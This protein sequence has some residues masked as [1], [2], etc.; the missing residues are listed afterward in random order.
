VPDGA[1][2]LELQQYAKILQSRG[3]LLAVCSKNDLESAVSGLNHSESLLRPDSFAALVANWSPKSDNISQIAKTLNIGLD[4][5]V[6][7][8]DNPAEQEIVRRNLPD[9]AVAPVGDRVETYISAIDRA[10]YFEIT[11]VTEEDINRSAMY[12][13]NS[14]RENLSS[15]FESYAEYLVSL[16]M[17]AKIGPFRPD[18][19]NRIH[20]LINKTN[21]FNLT[22]KRC[23]RE[24]VEN[25]SSSEL[26]IT[27]CGCLTDRFGDSGL[28]SIVTA[29]IRREEAMVDIWLMSCRVLKRGLEYAMMG[30]LVD[31]CL[32]KG[33]M[34]LNATYIKSPKNKMV[35]NL[36]E[37]LGFAA[38]H[39]NHHGNSEWVLDLD[40]P[41]ASRQHYIKVENT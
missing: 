15:S 10:G 7:L 19:Y 36:L 28:V 40:T 35:Q 8:D 25:W 2:H 4:S 16:D 27:L 41:Y 5:L 22:T 31:A 9:V 12:R 18:H 21:Q 17:Q 34:R 38:K 6:F 29:D 3:I 33:I 13:E 24:E 37:E 30:A 32:A 1:A 23:S 14:V 11:S 26:K 20:Q 39:Q